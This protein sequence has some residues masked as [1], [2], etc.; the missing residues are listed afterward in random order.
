MNRLQRNSNQMGT[1][2]AT[3]NNTYAAEFATNDILKA[4]VK[5]HDDNQILIADLALQQQK[6]S[7]IDGLIHDK[8]MIRTLNAINAMRIVNGI[9]AYAVSVNNQQL[10]DS[11]PFTSSYLTNKPEEKAFVA[12]QAIRDIALQYK[13]EILPFG[14]SA[15]MITQ[16][17]DDTL[18]FQ[19]LMAKPK[20]MR[21]DQKKVTQ[22]LKEAFLAMTTHLRKTLDPLVRSNFAATNDYFMAYFNSRITYRT[23]NSATVLRG[24]ITDPNGHHIKQA[25]VEL[26]NYPTP[27]ESTLRLTDAKGYYSF[28]RLDL[29]T[30]T[31]LV[32]AANYADGHF[33][34]TLLKDKDNELN[35]QLTPAPLEVPVLV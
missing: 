7:Q 13:T 16:I 19:E 26:V 29:A 18:T 5:K 1:S 6:F 35:M 30:A 8:N 28:K 31:I 23:G 9:K 21:S 22:K 4:A 34:K 27:G 24:R 15:Q 32:K 17:T 2:V 11:V 14:V 10:I 25:L 33:T 3:T 12:F 20:S